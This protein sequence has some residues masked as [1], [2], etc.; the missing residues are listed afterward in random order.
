MSIVMPSKPWACWCMDFIGPLP[1]T[2]RGNDMIMVIIDK[3]TRYTYYIPMKSTATAQEVFGLVERYVLA[4]RDIPEFI[5]SD[6]DTKFTS[7]FWQSLWSIWT[8]KLKMST[9]F[10]P[11][12]DGETERA[13]R[14]LI[15]MLRSYVQADQ[16]DWD[17]LLP[18]MQIANNDAKCQSTGKSPFEMNNGRVR[19]TLLDVELEAAGVA[20]MGAY[21][22]AQKLAEKIREMHKKATELVEKAQKKQRE[23]SKKGR[24]EADIK[25]GDLVLLSRKNLKEQYGDA[26][27]MKT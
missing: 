3:F 23:D 1:K 2:V 21:P 5:I 7:H 17:I 4:E 16:M 11:Q 18:W 14:T 10:H 13:N 8:T 22:G 19:R 25:E 12:T 27:R 26:P 6:R 24:R 20:R 9:S 15:E